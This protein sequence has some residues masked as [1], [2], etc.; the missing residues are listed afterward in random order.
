MKDSRR[1]DIG[2]LVIRIGVGLVMTAFGSQKLFGALGGAG[3]RGTIDNMRELWGIHPIFS[4]LAMF[5]ELLGGIGIAFGLFTPLSA[6]AIAV[7]MLVAVYV[8]AT[9]PGL[10]PGL[11]SGGKA[12]YLSRLSLPLILFLCAVG[13]LFTGPGKIS[14][15][16]RLFRSFR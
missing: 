7:T 1:V 3:Y 15:D 4:N 6:F 11:V 9:T 14:I 5:A 13:L 2:L 10:L 12:E 8:N 16:N